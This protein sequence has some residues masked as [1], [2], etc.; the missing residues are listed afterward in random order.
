MSTP[1]AQI[2]VNTPQEAESSAV[3]S[4]DNDEDEEM[5]AADGSSTEVTE[6]KEGVISGNNS[7]IGDGKIEGVGIVSEGSTEKIEK[8]DNKDK[9]EVKRGEGPTSVE[10]LIKRGEDKVDNVVS[11][12][13]IDKINI[14]SI[15]N[16][17]IGGSDNINIGVID[18]TNISSIDNTN[19]SSIDNIN[20]SSIG[21]P[22]TSN[23][24]NINISSSDS[25]NISSI[26]SI[27][28]SSID[29][30][31]VSNVDN[32]NIG[33][34]DNTSGNIDSIDNMSIAVNM[35]I[36]GDGQETSG[37]KEEASQVG[38]LKVGEFWNPA[39]ESTAQSSEIGEQNS[40]YQD[41]GIF[42]Q[43]GNRQVNEV[44]GEEGEIEDDFDLDEL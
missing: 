18:N 26:D 8:A 43:G 37:E 11:I 21:N 40:P 19:I 22:D 1:L 10:T 14:G 9:H 24:D 5:V 12:G 38:G 31:N 36:F 6:K 34:G 15:D 35:E 16:I 20:I 13:G 42:D 44:G 30:T 2:G 27:I 23:I 41:V 29:N 33:S 25:I 7:R 3:D 17:N 28:I 32:I 4:P 39:G